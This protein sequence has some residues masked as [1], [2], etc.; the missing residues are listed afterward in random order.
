MW[1]PHNFC[2]NYKT[3]D[4]ARVWIFEYIEL[5]YN[6]KRRHSSLGQVSPHE[7]EQQPQPLTVSTFRG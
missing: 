6:R 5:F 7:Y 1:C 3:V 4:E 2:E